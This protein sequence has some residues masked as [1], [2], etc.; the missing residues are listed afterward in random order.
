LA[1]CDCVQWGDLQPPGTS[2][3]A[4]SCSQ[5]REWRGHSDTETLLAEFEAWEI[6][7]TLKKMVG[8]FAIEL[9]DREEK[10]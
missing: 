1:I 7:A 8:M 3:I 4:S 2:W 6:E 10:C 9:W 5:S